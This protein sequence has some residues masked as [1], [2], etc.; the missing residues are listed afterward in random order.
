V[1]IKDAIK[2]GM[3][4]PGAK[5]EESQGMM[6]KGVRNHESVGESA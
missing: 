6:I 1:N 3:N 4:A 2:A 5:S